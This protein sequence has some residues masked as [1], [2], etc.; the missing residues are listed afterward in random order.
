MMLP[1]PCEGAAGRGGGAGFGARAGTSFK[2][3]FANRLF[4]NRGLYRRYPWAGGII[5]TAPYPYF[6]LDFLGAPMPSAPMLLSAPPE[7]PR[8]LS[9]QRSQ[10][11]VVVPS[12]DGGTRDIRVVRC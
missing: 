3:G 11:T 9:C 10:E 7:P 4:A 8:A 2:P 5:A 6:G 12:E 1:A